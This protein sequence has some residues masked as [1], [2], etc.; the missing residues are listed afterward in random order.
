MRLA[1]PD[2][3][4][5]CNGSEYGIAAKRILSR[6]QLAKRLKEGKS[7]LEKAGLKG[8]IAV[9]LDRLLPQRAGRAIYSS[10][11]GV[12]EAAKLILREMLVGERRT[13]LPI[14]AEPS[15]LG[16]IASLAVPGVC[17]GD[18]LIFTLSSAAMSS[19]AEKPEAAILARSVQLR[20]G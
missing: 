1:E 11:E 4:F 13:I 20:I 19:W 15:G 6:K 9:C 2:I 8:I 10:E 7:Q 5:R 14:L 12:E 3:V 16:I 18:R 17:K